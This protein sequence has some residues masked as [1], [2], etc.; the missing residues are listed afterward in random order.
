MVSLTKEKDARLS[1]ERSRAPI[2]EELE[3]A[4]RESSSANQKVLE[5]F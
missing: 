4:Q 2:L 3:R 1:V 5:C